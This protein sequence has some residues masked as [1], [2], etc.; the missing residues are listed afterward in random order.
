[1]DAWHARPSRTT[2][3]WTRPRAYRAN[4]PPCTS[5]AGRSGGRLT[6]FAAGLVASMLALDTVRSCYPGV[7]VFKFTPALQP[8]EATVHECR[9]VGPVSGDGFGYWWHCA[10]TVQTRDGREVRT[11][12]SRRTMSIMELWCLI[13]CCAGALPPTTTP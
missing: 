5:G 8:V 9:R 4:R 2:A 7:G 10:V 3:T 11:V 13:R 6:Q 1:M 12:V